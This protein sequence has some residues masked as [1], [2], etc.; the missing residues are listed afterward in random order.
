MS[1]CCLSMTSKFVPLLFWLENWIPFDQNMRSGTKSERNMRRQ[2]GGHMNWARIPM[3]RNRPSWVSKALLLAVLLSHRILPH[4][5]TS[6]TLLFA[7]FC[8]SPTPF[9]RFSFPSILVHHN[10]SR[11]TR[12]VTSLPLFLSGLNDWSQK[13]STN[14]Q[15][16]KREKRYKLGRINSK[17]FWRKSTEPSQPKSRISKNTPEEPLE[18]RDTDG[19]RQS[20]MRRKWRHQS[21]PPTLASVPWPTNENQRWY[22]TNNSHRQRGL[23]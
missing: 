9:H 20:K 13:I 19:R 21:G 1:Q 3:C 23:S 17:G 15:V 12:G 14:T 8:S 16:Q 11:L 2:Q 5:A 7:P 6:S 10:I 18:Q 4:L 22:T